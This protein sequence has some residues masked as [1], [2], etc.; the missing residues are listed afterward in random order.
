MK[1]L[2]NINWKV[3]VEKHDLSCRKWLPIRCDQ[4]GLCLCVCVCVKVL[5]YKSFIIIWKQSF[6]LLKFILSCSMMLQ[7]IRIADENFSGS[8]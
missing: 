7:D 4:L 8:S 6:R 3:F 1:L 2:N 5:K